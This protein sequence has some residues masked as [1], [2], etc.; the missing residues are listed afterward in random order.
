MKMFV[1]HSIF[2]GFLYLSCGD[3]EEAE[4]NEF[5]DLKEK[6]HLLKE[7]S[8]KLDASDEARLKELKEKRNSKVRHSTCL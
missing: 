8:K 2:A 6:K 7:A 1:T 3:T 4:E 5:L